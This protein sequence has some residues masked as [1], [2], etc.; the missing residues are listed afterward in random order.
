MVIFGA[1]GDLTK[2]KLVPALYSLARDRLLPSAFSVVGV[3][4]RDIG[5]AGF[6]AQMRT[7]CDE[8]ARRRPV[9]ES[10]VGELQAG[11]L[12]LRGQLLRRGDLSRTSRSAARRARRPARHRRQPRLLSLGS[13]RRVPRHHRGARQGR[14]H[15]QEQ[16][17]PVHARHHREAIRP[18]SRIGAGAQPQRA[19]VAARG[20]D[21]PHRSLPRQ[22]DGP[23]HPRCSVSPTGGSLGA[24]V[25]QR[26]TWTTSRS[27][28]RR[29]S[30]WRG[31]AATSRARA[32]CATWCRTTCSSSSA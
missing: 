15:Q 22:G 21:L 1:S 26:S 14:A 10:A 19:R 4:R 3:A 9:E 2:R 28:S 7:S 20:S 31:A 13:A 18:R 12:L 27:P 24:A 29:P 30:A 17:R 6:R 23:E 11:A 5:D 8:F 16:R 32:S 25:E